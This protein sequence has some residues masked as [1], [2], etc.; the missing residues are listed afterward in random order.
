[1]KTKFAKFIFVFIIT[2]AFVL[3]LPTFVMADEEYT[4]ENDITWTYTVNSDK[5]LNNNRVFNFRERYNCTV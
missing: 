5:Y 4:D 1:M 2:A 3:L